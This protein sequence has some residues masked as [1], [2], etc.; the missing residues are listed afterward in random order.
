MHRKAFVR[1]SDLGKGLVLALRPVALLIAPRLATNGGEWT[2]DWLLFGSQ[3]ASSY[4]F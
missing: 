4:I 2:I 3:A 1:H